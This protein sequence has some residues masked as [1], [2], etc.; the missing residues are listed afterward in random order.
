[1]RQTV[2]N[3]RLK[4]LATKTSKKWRWTRY[5]PAY[6]KRRPENN[7]RPTDTDRPTPTPGGPFTI[8]KK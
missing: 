4:E 6:L 5:L 8:I 3:S 7:D 2:K 1:M